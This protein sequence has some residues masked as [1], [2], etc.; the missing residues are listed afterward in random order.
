MADSYNN[1]VQLAR[2]IQCFAKAESTR[3]TL[4]WPDAGD[5][6]I[7]AGTP[8]WSQVPSYTDSVEVRDSRSR[9]NRFRDQNPAGS[10][11]FPVYPR[12]AGSLGV[13]PQEAVVGIPHTSVN[14]LRHKGW[15]D[16]MAVRVALLPGAPGLLF[17][18]SLSGEPTHARLCTRRSSQ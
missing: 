4:V 6:I 1:V 18:L 17:I 16:L 11:S 7:P 8:D 2:K 15:I 13:V 3:G 10:W 14:G 5:Y 12:P 9:R